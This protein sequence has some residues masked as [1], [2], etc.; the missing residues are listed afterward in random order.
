[1]TFFAKKPSFPLMLALTALL[2]V[3]PLSLRAD[4]NLPVCDPLFNQS[5][6]DKAIAEA[7]R[8]VQAN[9]DIITQP[10]SILALSCFDEHIKQLASGSGEIFVDD[11]EDGDVVP[12]NDAFNTVFGDAFDNYFKNNFPEGEVQVL[13]VTGEYQDCAR[14]KNLWTATR[15]RDIDGNDFLTLSEL[16]KFSKDGYDQ[17]SQ[18]GG[19]CTTTGNLASMYQRALDSSGNL[20]VTRSARNPSG[21]TSDASY[22]YFA[23][24]RP[25]FCAINPKTGTAALANSE[26]CKDV[27]RNTSIKCSSLPAIPTGQVITY[28]APPSG[29]SKDQQYWAYRCINPGCYFDPV[30]NARDIRYTAGGSPKTT[31]RCTYKP[32]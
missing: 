23:I 29:L 32:Y 3:S 9:G 30:A 15:C 26:V 16:Q 22:D 6:K 25:D 12:M 31:L 10:P 17:R 27:D 14:L 1:M 24:A 11:E 4:P 7:Q 13:Y 19:K 2:C 28:T 18:T 20:E 21:R 8:E 5:L